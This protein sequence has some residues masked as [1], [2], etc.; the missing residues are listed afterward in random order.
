[1][2]NDPLPIE[3]GS[4]PWAHDSYDLKI[5]V[6][7]ATHR[8]W[9]SDAFAFELARAPGWWARLWQRLFLGWRWEPITQEETDGTS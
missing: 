7:G 5:S 3:L 1:M 4:A 2:P 8:L 9:I 6:A